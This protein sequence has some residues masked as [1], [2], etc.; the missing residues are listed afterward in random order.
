VSKDSISKSEIDRRKKRMGLLGGGGFYLRLCFA[1]VGRGLG[2]VWG[3]VG[4]CG[5][6]EGAFV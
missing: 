2:C 6:V 1:N 4:V 5:G 3:E